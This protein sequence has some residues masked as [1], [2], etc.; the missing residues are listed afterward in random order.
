MSKNKKVADI[1]V[2]VLTNAGVK[3]CYGIVGDTL[4]FVSEAIYQSDINWVHMR[5]EEA[6]AFAAGAEAFVTDRLTACAGSCGPGSLHFI[7]GLYE[8][9]RNNAPVI[10]I[11]SQLASS[12]LGTNFPQEV[13]FLDVYKNCSVFCQQLN[14]PLEARRV[15]TQAAQAALNKRGVAVVILPADMS[16][17][18]IADDHVYPIWAPKPI[19]RPNDDEIAQIIEL[20]AAGKKIGIYAGIG[21]KDAHDELIELAKLL[22]APIAHTSRAKDF[23][24][25]NNPFNVGMT[26]MFGTKAG[27]EMIKH[28]DTLLL[29]GCGFAWSQFYPDK[30]TI[31]Q[32]D[33]DAMQLGLRHPIDFGA[34]GDIKATL[35]A[36]LPK[37]TPRTDTTFLDK[38]VELHQK[39]T[40]KLDKKAIADPKKPIHPQYLIDLIDTYASAQALFT[41]DVG[42]AMV[43]ACRH[44]KTNGQRRL[45]ISL[46]HGTM[47]NAMPQALGLQ[48]AFAD[49]QVIAM[50]GDG[51]LTMLLGDLLTAVQEKLPIKIFVLNNGS[52]NF[53]ELEQK[54][55]GLVNRYTDLHNGNLAMMAQAMGFFA[56]NI[57]DSDELEEAVKACL[58]HD[59]PALL[60]VYTSPNELIMPPTITMD[61]VASMTLYS[62]K[63]ILEGKSQDVMSLIKD[64]L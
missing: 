56:K 54:G 2:E 51:G 33:H 45:L 59:G 29:L 52:L 42:S 1:L 15:F 44:L 13:D 20:I 28:C 6:G 8:A 61:N 53:V 7:N 26:G 60:N 21:C 48:K 14:N 31:I 16:K 55:E 35:K 49:R 64:N 27:F 46:K 19:L 43:W 10:L 57:S 41:A 36:L 50:S 34:V 4:N 63:A 58:H 3:N 23:V 18:E 37:L 11:A 24:E 38:Y 62:A 5:H 17:A 47:A 32:I 30:A 12:S 40:I 22:N 25:Y 39:V 9:Q